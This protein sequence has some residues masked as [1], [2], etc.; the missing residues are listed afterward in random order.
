MG[1]ES[2]CT[3]VDNGTFRIETA[4]KL[5][6]IALDALPYSWDDLEHLRYSDIEGAKSGMVSEL[7]KVQHL[8]M[9]IVTQ[10]GFT[11]TLAINR[12]LAMDAL[13][14]S[15]MQ[16]EPVAIRTVDAQI[17]ATCS[18]VVDASAIRLVDA[19]MGAASSMEAHPVLIIPIAA[20]E[21]G[22]SLSVESDVSVV[23]SVGCG[24]VAQ[25]M[26]YIGLGTWLFADSDGLVGDSEGNLIEVL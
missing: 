25:S 21:I 7:A 17:D 15:W 4:M 10:S 6:V 13:G 9:P 20:Q 19:T 1:A 3:I 11:A 2:D 23:R 5:G 16:S 8:T 26:A 12:A 22:A 24:I 18:M 14:A